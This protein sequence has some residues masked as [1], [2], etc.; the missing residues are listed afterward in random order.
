MA[1]SQLFK[2]KKA[3]YALSGYYE[4]QWSP[5]IVWRNTACNVPSGNIRA[6]FILAQENIEVKQKTIKSAGKWSQKTPLS[7]SRNI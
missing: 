4:T 3:T 6:N 1:G 7:Q 2:Y 5:N